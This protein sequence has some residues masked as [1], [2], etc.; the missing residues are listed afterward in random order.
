MAESQK[1]VFEVLN[2]KEYKE[3]KI[4]PYNDMFFEIQNGA[5]SC[6]NVSTLRGYAD[7]AEALKIRLLNENG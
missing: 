1:R 3:S 6:T 2:T 7:R 4:N 5:E